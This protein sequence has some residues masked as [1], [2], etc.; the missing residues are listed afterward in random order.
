MRQSRR[1]VAA[2]AAVTVALPAALGPG[3]AHAAQKGGGGKAAKCS[4]GM[5]VEV[6]INGNKKIYVCTKKGKWVETL[7]LVAQ[8]QST[9]AAQ[10]AAGTAAR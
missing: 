6:T 8:P 9:T 10:A 7:N 4:P 3:A 1:I 5:V 2:I